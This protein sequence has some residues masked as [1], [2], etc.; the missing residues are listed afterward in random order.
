[1]TTV[2][3]SLITASKFVVLNYLSF[4]L[5]VNCR[6]VKRKRHVKARGVSVLNVGLQRVSVLTSLT[7]GFGLDP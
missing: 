7:M 2:K 4:P 1:M 3:R 6:H 5:N